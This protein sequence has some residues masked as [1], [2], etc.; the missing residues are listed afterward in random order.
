MTTNPHSGLPPESVSD[1]IDL[2]ELFKDA[3]PYG[4]GSDWEIPG[5]FTTEA[6]H[7]EFLA[8]YRAERQRDL[9]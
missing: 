9:A 3:K 8:W 6:E 4:D 7:Q 2:D 1:K 5:F